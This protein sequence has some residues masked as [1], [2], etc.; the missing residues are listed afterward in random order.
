MPLLVG[1]LLIL[2]L[3]ASGGSKLVV[4]HVED[5]L[6]TKIP[7]KAMGNRLPKST[8]LKCCSLCRYAINRI[9]AKSLTFFFACSYRVQSRSYTEKVD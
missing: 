6:L 1:T 4:V 7:Q 9:A 2:L 5:Y 8:D 3:K